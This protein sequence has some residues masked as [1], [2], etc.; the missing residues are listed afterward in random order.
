MKRAIRGKTVDATTDADAAYEERSDNVAETAEADEDLSG[1]DREAGT[2]PLAP[3]EWAEKD[4]GDLYQ[5]VSEALHH[6]NA[7]AG[8]E[9]GVCPPQ[10]GCPD[11]IVAVLA[12]GETAVYGSAKQTQRFADCIRSLG[13]QS[14]GMLRSILCAGAEQFRE[15]ARL[16]REKQVPV[17]DQDLR[18][19]S[20]GVLVYAESTAVQ[21]GLIDPEV[22][23]CRSFVHLLLDLLAARTLAALDRLAATH[24][25]LAMDAPEVRRRVCALRAHLPTME[26]AELEA[27]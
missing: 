7:Y 17:P 15:Y 27:L 6:V 22:W 11:R 14:T 21:N 13:L 23:R 9:D 18:C 3:I 2:A 10:A 8:A 1:L 19:G 16:K 5:R 24:H 12:Q 20:F 26:P 25:V 4:L